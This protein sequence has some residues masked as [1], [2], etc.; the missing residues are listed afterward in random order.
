MNKRNKNSNQ[1]PFRC[2]YFD[3]WE[4][5][6]LALKNLIL[7]FQSSTWMHREG[8]YFKM[9]PACVFTAWWWKDITENIQKTT[10]LWWFTNLRL[11]I[12][13]QTCG[14]ENSSNVKYVVYGQKH[15]HFKAMALCFLIW[16]LYVSSACRGANVHGFLNFNIRWQLN[17]G[18]YSWAADENFYNS[19]D[20]D[21]KSHWHQYVSLWT[22]KFLVR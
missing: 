3:K 11:E 13:L 6:P 15:E 5:K 8:S 19:L 7:R 20:A 12:S 21:L 1:W 9:V 2:T 18:S 4:L 16:S 10:F 22:M 17:Y 14:V